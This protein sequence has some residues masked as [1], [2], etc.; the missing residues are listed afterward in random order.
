MRKLFA[1]LTLALSSNN[2]D[3]Q[4]ITASYLQIY[5]KTTAVVPVLNGGNGDQGTDNSFSFSYEHFIKNKKYSALRDF[6]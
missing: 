1:F 2:I 6:M 3:G 5:S 4:S